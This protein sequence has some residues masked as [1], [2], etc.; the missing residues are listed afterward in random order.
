M[1]W[2]PG[3]GSV[4]QQ[5]V[6]LRPSWPTLRYARTLWAASLMQSTSS[7]NSRCSCNPMIRLPALPGPEVGEGCTDLTE[8]PHNRIVD[9]LVD[10]GPELCFPHK[11]REH[12]QDIERLK[13]LR[14]L[15]GHDRHAR[16][17]SKRPRSLARRYQPQTISYQI[18]W[19]V[20][21]KFLRARCRR[22]AS[23]ATIHC[24]APFTIGWEPEEW[25]RRRQG[26]DPG[27]PIASSAWQRAARN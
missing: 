15:R 25:G 20:Y 7:R 27:R 11:A 12:P 13:P 18:V 3:A 16:L 8:H 23:G 22:A 24:Q 21:C 14:Y 10:L 9:L 4:A 17:W 19:P 26:P 1:R 2:V 5:P 6:I